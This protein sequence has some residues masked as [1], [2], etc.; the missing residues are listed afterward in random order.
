MRSWPERQALQSPDSYGAVSRCDL[1]PLLSCSAYGQPFQGP[2]W[3]QAQDS[4]VV[5][6]PPTI[7]GCW[8]SADA[9]EVNALAR[10]SSGG[11]AWTAAL[12]GSAAVTGAM[13]WPALESAGIVLTIGPALEGPTTFDAHALL[14]ST[15]RAFGAHAASMPESIRVCQGTDR[16][17]GDRHSSD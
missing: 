11:A 10:S 17:N 16:L 6:L 14:D 2:I 7:F 8:T 9:A 5:F 12:A 1:P 15:L 3:L 13:V 4:W